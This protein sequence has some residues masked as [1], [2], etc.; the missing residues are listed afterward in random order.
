MWTL[1]RGS[2]DPGKE[3]SGLD[4]T[5][6]VLLVAQINENRHLLGEEELTFHSAATQS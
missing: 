4:R 2:V 6:M 1:K 3:T 5:E